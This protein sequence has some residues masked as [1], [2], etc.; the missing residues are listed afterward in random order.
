[1][2]QIGVDNDGPT[3]GSPYFRVAKDGDCLFS[4]VSFGLFN[5]TAKEQVNDLRLSAVACV[6]EY[7]EFVYTSVTNLCAPYEEHTLRV[8][9][10]EFQSM[11]DTAKQDYTI[12]MLKSGSWGSTAEVALFSSLLILVSFS[13]KT[14]SY[15]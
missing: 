11:V 6:Q 5:T 4:S 14:N 12:H 13:S 1:M 9:T 8:R 2:N 7:W 3:M 15:L 10:Q